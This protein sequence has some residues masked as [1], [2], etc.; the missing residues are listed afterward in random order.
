MI[1]RLLCLLPLLLV[2]C[3]KPP[4]PE[5]EPNKINLY[6][7]LQDNQEVAEAERRYLP[8]LDAALSAHEHTIT[9]EAFTNSA[10]S[11]ESLG[12]DIQISAPAE[13][14][15]E[16]EETIKSTLRESGAPYVTQVYVVT[17]D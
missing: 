2:S 13:M 4:A 12:I 9:I 14:T 10:G 11:V 6:A 3:S 15:A 1:L 7:L 17:P 16:L 8:A 5:P